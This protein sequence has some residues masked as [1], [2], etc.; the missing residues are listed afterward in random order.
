MYASQEERKGYSLARTVDRP[1]AEPKAMVY[2]GRHSYSLGIPLLRITTEEQR[3]L[4]KAKEEEVVVG[5]QETDE[6]LVTS[7]VP[8]GLHVSALKVSRV[9]VSPYY[10]IWHTKGT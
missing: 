2:R 10:L 7:L 8:G 5:G 9:T 4:G 1:R 3:K 6:H